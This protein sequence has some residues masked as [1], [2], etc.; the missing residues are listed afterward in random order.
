MCLGLLYTQALEGCCGFVGFFVLRLR[1]LKVCVYEPVL[2]V[3]Q[4]IETDQLVSKDSGFCNSDLLL[5][6]N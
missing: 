1:V 4:L 5:G 6:K 2:S 3:S